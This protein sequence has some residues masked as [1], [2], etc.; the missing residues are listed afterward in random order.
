MR[1]DSKTRT[2]ANKQKLLELLENR[3]KVFQD[4]FDNHFYAQD[5]LYP[6]YRET[7]MWREYGWN[8]GNEK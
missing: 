8:P 4:I 3:Q 6:L 2:D 1:T 7:S 5:V